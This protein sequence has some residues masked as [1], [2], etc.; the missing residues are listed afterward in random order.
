MIAFCYWF[1][2]YFV[3]PS[4]IALESLQFSSDKV[5]H[6]KSYSCNIHYMCSFRMFFNFMKSKGRI[7]NTPLL[8]IIIS[9]L[10]SND[11][12]SSIYSLKEMHA[13][14]C[15]N[16]IVISSEVN[17]I[18]AREFKVSVLVYASSIIFFRCE[19]SLLTLHIY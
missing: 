16:C 7:F 15:F 14:T 5:M 9:D 11:I 6:I 18:L 4:V 12:V 13:Y 2:F 10:W 17:I 1:S 19:F 3:F 8:F